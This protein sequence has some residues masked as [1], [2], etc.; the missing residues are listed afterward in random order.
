[1]FSFV[2]LFS[3][4]QIFL[5]TCVYLLIA[6]RFRYLTNLTDCGLRIE[7]DETNLGLIIGIVVAVVVVIIIIIIIIVVVIC[8]KKRRQ[9]SSGNSDYILMLFF[10]PQDEL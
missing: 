2:P 1:L 10:S 4:L 6:V 9:K 8:V 3:H 5:P 7:E